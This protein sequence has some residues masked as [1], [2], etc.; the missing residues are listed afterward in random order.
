M[1]KIHNWKCSLLIVS[2]VAL[3]PLSA[4]AAPNTVVVKFGVGPQQSAIELAR[5]WTPIFAYLGKKTGYNIQFTTAKD[6]PTYQQ[7]TTA[8]GVDMCFIYPHPYNI[9]HKSV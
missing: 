5:R 1:T 2:I 6:I 3:L 4:L 9:F 8:G 7:Q